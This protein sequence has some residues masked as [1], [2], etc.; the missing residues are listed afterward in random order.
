MG[1]LCSEKP[2]VTVSIPEL[3]L[4]IVLPSFL[5]RVVEIFEILSLND[6]SSIVLCATRIV[7]MVF[8]V[9]VKISAAYVSTRSTH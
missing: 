8:F 1:D 4:S 9:S 3:A 2:L 5:P 7:L 6:M